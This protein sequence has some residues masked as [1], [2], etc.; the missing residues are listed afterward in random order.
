MKTEEIVDHLLNVIKIG[1]FAVL[2]TPLILGPFGINF[3]EYPKAL[4]FRCGIEVL[5]VLYLSLVLFN[6]KYL[7]KKS[8]LTASIVL[9][10]AI[11]TISSIFGVNFTRSFFGTMQRGEGLILHFHL[12]AFFVIITSVFSGKK[13]WLNLLKASVIVS[14]ISSLAAILQQIGACS[15]YSMY[16]NFSTRL[17]GTLSNPDLFSS[18]IVLAIFITLFILIAESNKNLKLLWSGIII[19]NCYTL[20]FSGTR[21]SWLGFLAG[22]IVILIF[23]FFRLEKK[24]KIIISVCVLA[25]FIFAVVALL[26]LQWIENNLGSHYLVKRFTD[27]NF[28]DRVEIWKSAIEAIKQKPILGWG[29]ESFIFASDKFMKSGL[30]DGIYFDRPHNKVLESLEYGGI[31]GFVSYLL[32]FVAVCYLIFKYAKLWADYNNKSKILYS[33]I[34][35][36]LFVAGFVQNI[37]SFDNIS[38]YIL[39]FLVLGF[40]NNNFSDFSQKSFDDLKQFKIGPMFR[41]II[42]SLVSISMIWVLYVINIKPTIAAMY[43]PASVIYETKN[44]KKAFFGYKQGISMNTIYDSELRISFIDRML[45][46]AEG[47][48]ADDEKENIIKALLD[49]EPLIYQSIK[50][51]DDQINH[52]Y[53]YLARIY[54]QKY[55]LYKNPEDLIKFEEIINE[56]MKFNSS[57]SASFQFLAELNIFNGNYSEAEEY[58]RKYCSLNTSGCVGEE[59]FY[60]SMALSYLRTKKYELAA[61]SYQKALSINYAYKKE[62]PILTKEE[63]ENSLNLINYTAIAYCLKLK[64][65]D[66][67]KKVYEEAGVV[68]PEY[69]ET[70]GNYFKAV[71]SQIK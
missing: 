2:L 6:T 70:F 1:I 57:V 64:D 71:K 42:I 62:N 41:I 27:L 12:L 28:G 5:F 58:I 68:F 25:V 52:L 20:F 38:S 63:L 35:I 43:F 37:F 17:T 7:P 56:S 15:F 65:I 69:K 26:N 30:S 29:F 34:L 61:E 32:I 49:I 66:S 4:F 3:A 40:I 11:M 19:L 44:V 60:K 59:G 21:A 31:L 33:S 46:L 9:F 23:N 45:Y 54:E 22:I 53:Q 14:G 39:Y 50:N 48:T 51:N 36:A 10:I 18:Y 16:K 55:L 67:C 24:K 8:I 47:D 13:D